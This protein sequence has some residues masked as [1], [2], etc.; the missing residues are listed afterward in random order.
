[1]IFTVRV[2]RVRANHIKVKKAQLVS[3][4]KENNND[5]SGAN[6]EDSPSQ[7]SSKENLS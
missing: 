1:M 3:R 4:M 6:E 7:N 2:G 5:S